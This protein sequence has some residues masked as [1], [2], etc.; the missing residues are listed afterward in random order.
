[1]ALKL[2]NQVVG[3]VRQVFGAALSETPNWLVRPGRLECGREWQ[4]VR[5]IYADLTGE[6]LPDVMRSVERRTV[7]AVL[8]QPG[9]APR[10]LEVDEKQHFNEFRA[11]TLQHYLDL[12]VAFDR[13]AWKTA[14]LAKRRLEG[15]GFARP[16]APLFPGLNGR[17]RQRAFRDAL[18]DILPTVHGFS[19]TL[20]IADFEV[21]SWVFLPNA[22]ERMQQFLCERLQG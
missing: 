20:R 14:S 7:D 17:H 10:I 22:A 6:I 11:L 13:D 16:M 3:L 18:C 2:Q 8:L 21:A 15:G 12:P 4:R 1:M 9:S 5:G 19:P